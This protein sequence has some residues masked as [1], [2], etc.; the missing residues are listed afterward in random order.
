[1]NLQE[2]QTIAFH[3]LPIKTFVINNAGY[4]SMRQTEGNLFPELTPVGIGPETGD[5]SFPSIKRISEAYGIRYVSASKNDKVQQAVLDTLQGDGPAICELFCVTDQKFE[6]KSATKKLEDGTL[7]SPPLE[8]L[9]PFLSRE[10][11]ASN[12]LIPLWEG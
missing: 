12:M 1:M 11:L 7:V 6:P 5:L 4:H 9:A 2:L 10:E 3:N 8:D